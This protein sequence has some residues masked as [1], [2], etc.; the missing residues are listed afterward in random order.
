MQM[1][2]LARRGKETQGDTEGACWGVGPAW[3]SPL[4]Q[5]SRFQ[6]GGGGAGWGG[7]IPGAFAQ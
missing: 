7:A 2:E 4:P 1:N 5:E 3:V 6:K